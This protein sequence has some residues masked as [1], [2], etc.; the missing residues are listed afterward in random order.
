[1]YKVKSLQ[2]TS[3]TAL[4]SEHSLFSA[5]ETCFYT[6]REFHPS[7]HYVTVPALYVNSVREAGGQ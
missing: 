7:I 4:F 5:E 6:L 1:M 3:I 2:C